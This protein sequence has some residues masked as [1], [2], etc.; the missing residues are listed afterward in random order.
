MPSSSNRQSNNLSLCPKKL[1]Q[2]NTIG[3]YVV[4][5][6]IQI[7]SPSLWDAIGGTI[8]NI[9]DS[10]SQAVDGTAAN[11]KTQQNAAQVGA[12]NLGSYV[13]NQIGGT[14]GDYECTYD[15]YE[16]GG[17]G[18]SGCTP[19]TCFVPVNNY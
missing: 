14:G 15:W 2:H 11:G 19:M 7:Y 16:F 8:G 9:V 18:G 12:F 1:D 3:T 10:L 5:P 17:G 13:G 6:L 4:A